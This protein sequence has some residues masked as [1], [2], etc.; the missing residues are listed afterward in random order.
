PVT[1][2]PATGPRRSTRAASSRTSARPYSTR[3]VKCLWKRRRQSEDLLRLERRDPQLGGRAAQ[4]RSDHEQRIEVVGREVVRCSAVRLGQT[5]VDFEAASFT[6]WERAN[7]GNPSARDEDRPCET[8]LDRR[9]DQAAARVAQLLQ[10]AKG[11]D[12]LF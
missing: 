6:T 9:D 11:S 7:G 4:E 2:S 8:G 3:P 1:R 5:G 10:A 12:D